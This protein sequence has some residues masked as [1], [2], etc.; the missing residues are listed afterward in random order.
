MDIKAQIEKHLA[1]F[2]D[3][4]ALAIANDPLLLMSWAPLTR[5]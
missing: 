5:S 1:Q 3:K 2:W 4:R